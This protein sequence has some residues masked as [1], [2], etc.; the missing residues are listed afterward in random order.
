[1]EENNE[2]KSHQEPHCYLCGNEGSFLFKEVE[3]RIYGAPG[4]WNIKKCTNS[5]CSLL[6]LDPMPDSSELWKAYKNYY[7]HQ[8]SS[9]FVFKFLQPFVKPYLSLFYKYYHE[10]NFFKKLS[11]LIFI[12]LPTEK[13]NVDFTVLWLKNRAEKNLLDIGCGNGS[14]METMN[15]LGWSAT[16]IDFD[17]NAVDYCVSRGLNAIKG[18]LKELNF[19]SAS[20]DVVT[21]NHVLEHL[22]DSS[23]T[24][25]E[26]F[27]ILKPDGEIVITTPNAQSW[28]FNK[29]FKAS[30]Y[31]LQAPAH[32]HI[33]SINNL[34]ALLKNKGFTIS[35]ATTTTRIE[36]WIYYTSRIIKKEGT[37]RPDKNYSKVYHIFGRILQLFTMVCLLFNK[38]AGNEIL[39]TAKK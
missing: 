4:K 27:R 20:F 2:I 36:G 39:I 32:L 34:S 23:G 24:M 7:T 35:R 30:W 6:W 22:Y 33:F 16:G 17:Q 14:F 26:C 3:D 9:D 31:A 19:P 15:R 13:V 11:G 1:M 18:D 21:L 38:T 10:L 37:F 29:W 8:G 28:M 25:E 12:L 5:Q